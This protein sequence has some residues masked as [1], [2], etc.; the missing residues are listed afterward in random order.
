MQQRR[1]FTLVELLVVIAIIAVLIGLLLPAV[2]SARESARRASCG[3]NLKQLGLGMQSHL[4]SMQHF[5]AG[6]VGVIPGHGGNAWDS[7]NEYTWSW[8]ALTLPYIDQQVLHDR[9]SP[10]TRRL[11]DHLTNGGVLGDLQAPLSVFRCA[12]DGEF[13]DVSV[14]P[15]RMVRVA[16]LGGDIGT[17]ASS[18]VASNTG[19]I[20]HPGG[21]FIG[22]PP[23]GPGAPIS[24]WGGVDPVPPAGGCFWRDSNLLP[25]QIRDG[26]S[27]T[28]MLG[29]RTWANGAG[30][31]LATNA[32]NEQLSVESCLGTAA[33]QI[34]STEP[35]GR[36]RGFTSPHAGSLQFLFCDGSVRPIRET[37]E[38]TILR[39]WNGGTLGSLSAFE[40]LVNRKDGQPAPDF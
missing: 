36:L 29:E 8:G 7:N 6:Y 2:Q 33:E 21:R 35:W 40:R 22:G 12:S 13:Q 34:N 24:Q 30:L 10:R 20:W 14:H 37:I 15:N 27:N 26:L 11:Y 32:V 23:G 18:Y 17:T 16:S 4:S 38:H 5:P 28:I 19:Y 39:S 3:N 9:L 1:G 31:A 25:A